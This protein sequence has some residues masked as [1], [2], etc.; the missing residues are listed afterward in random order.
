MSQESYLVLKG[1]KL[2]MYPAL[3]MQIV[4]KMKGQSLRRWDDIILEELKKDG[5]NE[6][7]PFYADQPVQWDLPVAGSGQFISYDKRTRKVLVLSEQT[8]RKHEVPYV[9][10]VE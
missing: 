10:E 3:R 9:Y 1:R 8:G 6:P 5:F 2:N 4:E 7:D